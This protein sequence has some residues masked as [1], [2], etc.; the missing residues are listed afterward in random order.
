VVSADPQYSYSAAPDIWRT[1]FA[2][3]ELN[4]VTQTLDQEQTLRKVTTFKPQVAGQAQTQA[5][6]AMLLAWAMII[7]YIWIRFGQLRYGVAG[8]IALVHDVLIALAF[9][10]ISGWIGGENHPIGRLLGIEDFKIDMT[11]IAALLTLIGY[12]IND[13][14]VIFD[15]IREVRG[16]LGIVTPKTIN[17]SL[18][19]T[20]SRTLLTGVTVLVVLLIMYIFGGISIRGFNY[21]MFIGVITGTYSSIAIAAP[22]LLFGAKEPAASR[23]PSGRLATA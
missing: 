1:G 16:R 9:V 6:L 22:L 11:I 14:I 13:K 20:L 5:V 4:L 21:C 23:A 17:D 15:R 2:K 8:V 7:A 12:S 19:Q 10:G 18:N 3:E